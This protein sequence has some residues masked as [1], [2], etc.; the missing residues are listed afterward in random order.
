MTGIQRDIT[1]G[2]CRLILGDCRD[3]LPG[4]RGVAD[5]LFCDVA[6][7]LTSGGCANQSMGGIFTNGVYDNKGLLMDVPPWEDL[8]GPFF[9]A[10]KADADA[11]IMAND[12]NLFRAGRA[13]E[14]AG[15]RFHNLLV[16][17]KIRATRNRWYMKNLEFTIY[18]WKG[19]AR[20]QGINDCGSKQSFA[21]NAPRETKHPTEK[22]VALVEHYVLNSTQPGDLVLDPMMGSG[23][24]L[25]AAARN[26]RK[27]IGV[28]SDPHWFDVAA[29]RVRGEYA[30]IANDSKGI[31]A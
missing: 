1:I 22:P 25:V 18:L 27:A 14:G 6:Y 30:R 26:G 5:M 9:R 23:T 28:E 8:G 16:W 19:R 29:A 24:A 2:D 21:L 15:W 17:D 7:A 12:K 4:L 31:W 11:Y 10:C 13:F 3:V 20:P